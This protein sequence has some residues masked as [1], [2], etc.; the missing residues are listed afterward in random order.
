[1]F[2]E[3]EEQKKTKAVSLGKPAAGQC[4]CGK[5]AFEKQDPNLVLRERELGKLTGQDRG[6]LQ[7]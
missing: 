3:P 5:V 1:M 6:I 7:R 4:L 2:P